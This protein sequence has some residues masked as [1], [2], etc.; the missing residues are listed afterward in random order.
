MV[1]CGFKRAKTGLASNRTQDDMT[2]DV[3]EWTH[4]RAYGERALVS[5]V[6]A[7]RALLVRKVVYPE[8]FTLAWRCCCVPH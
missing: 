4:P 5:S 8:L 7:Q 3:I 6:A 1:S 2:V